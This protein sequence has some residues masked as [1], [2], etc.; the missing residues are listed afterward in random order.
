MLN[1]LIRLIYPAKNP[2]DIA[3]QYNI[4]NQIRFNFESS[5]DGWIIATSE[6]L[7]GFITEARNPQELLQM[8][9]DGILT[10]FNVPKKV[11]DVVHNTMTIDGCGTVSLKEQ[12][13]T[14]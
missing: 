4:P 14:A 13:Q 7:P 3:K 10:Y 2:I 12:L 1:K 5:K 9:N 11:G 6:D 8:I